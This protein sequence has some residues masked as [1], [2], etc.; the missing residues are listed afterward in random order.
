MDSE[1]IRTVIDGLELWAFDPPTNSFRCGV[2]E[3]CRGVIKQNENGVWVHR[4]LHAQEL[5]ERQ[6]EW[7]NKINGQALYLL[8]RLRVF[9]VV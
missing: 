2:E 8:K 1:L 7:K 5:T 4:D 6:L 9:E 3:R